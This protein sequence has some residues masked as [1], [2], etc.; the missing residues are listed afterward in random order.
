ML[1]EI[2]RTVDQLDEL[3]AAVANDGAMVDGRVHPG[4]VE[5]RNLRGV[6]ARLLSSL[7]LP[8]GDEDD[9]LQ[10]RRPQRRGAARGVYAIGLGGAP[11]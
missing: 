8:S 7:R 5:S 9:E 1:K 3:A 4:L 11:E 10:R 6:L 2:V